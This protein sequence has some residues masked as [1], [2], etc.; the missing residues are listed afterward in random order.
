MEELG[1]LIEDSSRTSK[2][3]QLKTLGN[4]A[5]AY[6]VELVTNADDSYRRLEETGLLDKATE[7]PIYIEISESRGSTIISVT[8]NA[9]G[10][11]SQRIKETF[12]G[13][14]YGAEN[15]GG[16]LTGSRGIFGQGATD[17]MVNSAMDKKQAM[18]ESF[19]DGEFSKFYFEWDH[20]NGKRILKPKYIKI[21]ES[22]LSDKRKQL[23]IPANGT[24]M[25]FGVPNSVKF[26][27]KSLVDDL[28]GSYSL[29]YILNSRNRRVELI[30]NN[31]NI[32]LSS[33]NFDLSSLPLINEYQFSFVFDSVDIKCHLKLYS[34]MIKND[35]V[36]YSSQILVI[37]KNF[38]VYANTL[39]GFEKMPKAKNISGI[40]AIDGIYKLAKNQL[41]KQNPEEI[42]NDDRTGF[43]VKHD[44]YKLL[45]TKFLDPII[46]ESLTRI[47]TDIDNLDFSNNKKFKDALS[48]INKWMS[49][50]F[51]NDIPGGAEKGV[52]PPTDGLSF[53]RSSIT[54]TKGKVYS[55]KIIINPE[56]VYENDDIFVETVNNYGF[57]TFSPQIVNY[58]KAEID[59]N[60][61]VVKSITINALEVTNNLEFLVLR[62]SSKN[63]SKSLNIQVVDI[64]L[65]A[66]TNGMAFDQVDVQFIP[67]KNHTSKVWFDL[68]VF[69]IGTEV[70]FKSEGL[71]VINKEVLIAEEMLITNNIGLF[72]VET[73]GGELNQ[74]YK[75]E[76]YV[77]NKDYSFFQ[78]ITIKNKLEKPQGNR[79]MI[80]A[81][82]GWIEDGAPFQ[83]T[84]DDKS[85]T[86]FV[87]L[88]N[89]INIEMMGDLT[90]IDPDNPKFNER[91]LRYL[92]DLL[93][94]QS[95]VIDIKELERKN[96][97]TINDQDKIEDYINHL[98]KKKTQV[99]E[100]I[101]NSLL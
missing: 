19:K 25:T 69:G 38:N 16:E 52:T 82:K 20:I 48:A 5:I 17:V 47:H 88:K 64:E 83:V 78:K 53:S 95:A 46:K 42:I 21:I 45:T 33:S 73:S 59:E 3:K 58:K 28:N 70:V 67:D 77:T 6:I 74:S 68:N 7:K 11:S 71:E 61:I 90:S 4:S 75:L 54:I 22:Q 8:D 81:I 10:M 34:N 63:Y 23:R 50:E 79:G 62:V 56:L 92:A 29:R 66:A 18:L 98:N 24:K 100:R 13:K 85:G 9:E 30:K 35:N 51:K 44:F 96:Q 89:L 39:F 99:F 94:F 49:E 60:N 57:I 76:G 91:Q 40:L 97:I 65:G 93:A 72:T 31:E 26:K 2:R 86:I 32:V 55:L 12:S 43:N 37:D 15:S 84:F 87:N 14:S 1:L 41:N 36:E 101:I 27:E 80:T